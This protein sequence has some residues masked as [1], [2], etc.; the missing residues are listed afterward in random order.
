MRIL[1]YLL[2]I[3][4]ASCTKDR[5]FTD[6][7]VITPPGQDTGNIAPGV[8]RI[9]EYVAKG[10]L[11]TSNLGLQSDWIELYNTLDS[12]IELEAGRWFITD[13]ISEPNMFELPALS[14]PAHSHYVIFCE[15]TMI[16]FNNQ[17]HTNFALSASGDEIGLFYKRDEGFSVIDSTRFGPQTQSNKSGAR[18]PDGSANWNYPTEPTPG[19]PNQ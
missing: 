6:D 2:L 11:L 16:P 1:I 19:N 8:I 15:D 12:P 14:L 10:S 7:N 3:V 9:N 5:I 18:I 4:L 17:V 13:D